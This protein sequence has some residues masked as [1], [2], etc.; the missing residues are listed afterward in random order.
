MT[1][2]AFPSSSWKTSPAPPSVWPRECAR[3]HLAYGEVGR[4]PGAFDAVE[5]HEALLP[6]CLGA[7]DGEVGHRLAL[8]V[9]LGA[10]ARVVGMQALHLEARIVAADEVEEFVELLR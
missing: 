5:R 6:M 4:Q 1:L 10:H 3:H 2:R 8:A 9:E 7:V